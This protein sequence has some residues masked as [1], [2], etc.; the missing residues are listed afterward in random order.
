MSERATAR[1]AKKGGAGSGRLTV[2]EQK[3]EDSLK[4]DLARLMN[5]LLPGE[6]AKSSAPPPKSE[7][8]LLLQ[9]KAASQ[10]HAQ[11]QSLPI[12]RP[13]VKTS[14]SSEASG[15]EPVSDGVNADDSVEDTRFTGYY[16]IPPNQQ[17]FNRKATHTFFIQKN[18][19][20]CYFVP[21]NILKSRCDSELVGVVP[22]HIYAPHLFLGLPLPPCPYGC[23]WNSVDSNDVTTNGSCEARRI[24][25]IE[26]DEFLV[27]QGMICK[28]HQ[29]MRKVVNI[30][31]PPQ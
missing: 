18:V 21:K 30:M 7:D 20:S 27:G 22:L 1:K 12:G 26:S 2:A 16:A 19:T 13:T 31:V 9:A 5:G 11:Q 29:R 28:K 15:D 14:S 24:M 23:G 10:H 6:G 17:A 4:N 3:V 25:G 8:A